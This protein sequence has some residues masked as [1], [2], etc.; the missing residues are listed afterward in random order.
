VKQI[1]I[2]GMFLGLVIGPGYFVYCKLFSGKPVGTYTVAAMGSTWV[3]PY[4]I[5][6]SDGHNAAFKPFAVTLDPEMEPLTFLLHAHAV[7]DSS[8]G[9]TGMSLR[10]YYEASLYLEGQLVQRAP[11]YLSASKKEGASFARIATNIDFSPLSRGGEYYFV[12]S[13]KT[14]PQLDLNGVEVEI[15][16]NALPVAWPVLWLGIA[17]F[18]VSA[19]A[20]GI[21]QKRQSA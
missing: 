6:I 15:R 11:V 1:A 12:L 4:G 13:E 2:A 10:N 3:L 21:M 14:K 9:N 5:T 7:P 19:I 20:A 17:I 8:M 18:L 16:R